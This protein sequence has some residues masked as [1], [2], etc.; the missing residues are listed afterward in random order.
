MATRRRIF[1]SLPGDEWLSAAQNDMKWAVVE[2]IERVGL[3]SEIFLDPRGTDSLAAELAWSAERAEDI[4]RR[5]VGAAFIG[6]PRWTFGAS[7]S[8]VKLVSEFCQYEGALARAL[9]P[10]SG[11]PALIQQP[12]RATRR[13]EVF[14]PREVSP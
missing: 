9:N 11:A 8:V 13:F 14:V 3:T 4:M 7:D 5:C 1:I 12:P 10:F 2:R 6:M